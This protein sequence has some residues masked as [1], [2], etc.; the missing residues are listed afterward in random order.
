M[1]LAWPLGHRGCA[2]SRSLLYGRRYG[3][4][5]VLGY[6]GAWALAGQG[7]APGGTAEHIDMRI[8]R[9]AGDAY[10]R[11]LGWLE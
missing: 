2:R 3:V 7:L 8:T 10:A 4:K 1:R 11:T 9:E 5:E 6:L